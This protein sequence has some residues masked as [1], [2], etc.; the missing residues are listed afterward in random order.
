M[1]GDRLLSAV[2]PLAEDKQCV[3]K[4]NV[5]VLQ[6]IFQHLSSIRTTFIYLFIFIEGIGKE[7]GHMT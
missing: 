1:I 2:L 4:V 5:A 7:G 3:Y 6:F